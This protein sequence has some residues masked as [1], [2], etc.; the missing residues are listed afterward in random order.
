[1][2]VARAFRAQTGIYFYSYDVTRNENKYFEYYSPHRIVFFE[3][4][5]VYH[6]EFKLEDGV[7]LNFDTFSGFL[8]ENL[9]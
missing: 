1:M 6:K 9:G 2:E 7:E 4:K 8:M 3:P 5:E